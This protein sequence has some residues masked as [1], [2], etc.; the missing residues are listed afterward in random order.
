MTVPEPP[1]HSC[2]NCGARLAG[3]YCSACGQPARSPLTSVR[4]FA[5]H[6]LDDVAS[7][8]SRLMRTLG[9]LFFRPGRLSAEYLAGRRIR[10]TYPVQL[11]LLAAATFF[12]VASFRPFLWVDTTHRMVRGALPGMGVGNTL[13]HRTLQ[14]IAA[15]GLSLDLFAAH[16]EDA[17]NAWLPVFL[18]GSVALFSLVLYA[19]EFRRERR[20]LPH[21]VF[22]LHWTAFYLFVMAAARL[23]PATRTLQQ[24]SLFLAL[25]WLTAALRRVY[26]QGLELSLVKAFVLLIAFLVMLV[27]WVQSAVAIGML[28]V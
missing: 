22:T 9:A 5:S 1:P 21:A 26:G 6:V 12:L 15:S 28:V 8:D 25:V 18:V 3:P 14:R 7:L 20:Y 11:Y 17:V 16:F 23:L 13:A 10:Y 4:T 19:F 2:E 24:L 27:V